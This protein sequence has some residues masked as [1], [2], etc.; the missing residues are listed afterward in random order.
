MNPIA[1]ALHVASR[2]TDANPSDAQKSAGNYAKGKLRIEGMDIAI[3]NPKGS[4]RSGVDPNGKRWECTLP[5]AYGYFLGTVGKDGDHVD[6]YI[7]DDHDSKKVFVIDQIDMKTG[8][9]D[10]HKV[11]LSFP[12][13]D[14]AVENYKKAFSDGNGA[15]RIGH[16]AEMS[17]ERFKE[18]LQN[19]NTKAPIAKGYAS[20][21]AVHGGATS[22]AGQDQSRKVMQAIALA[23][24]TA[25][26]GSQERQSRVDGGRVGRADGGPTRDS[27]ASR[28]ARTKTFRE[29]LESSPRGRFADDPGSIRG[30]EEPSAISRAIGV[31]SMPARL[32]ADQFGRATDSVAEAMGDPSLPNL[33][34]AGVQTGLT[35]GSP[36]LTGTSGALGF[37]LA[38]ARDF[39]PSIISSAGAKETKEKRR[40]AD[41]KPALFEP[42][43]ASAPD[44]IA[45]K[46]K[47]DPTLSLLHS[48]IEAARFDAGKNYPG[49][50]GDASRAQAA[51]R[52][53]QLQA[54]MAEEL[55]KR[56]SAKRDLEKGNYDR[57]V[58]DA[59][60]AREKARSRDK[61]FSD[62]EVGKVYDKL[63]GYAPV[64]AG[65]VPGAAF[66][67]AKGPAKT[68]G[69]ALL[70]AGTGAG[71]GV[72]AIN[73][74]IGYDMA[75]SP[76]VN[77]EKEA[78]RAYAYNLP[79]G[80]PDKAKSEKM[81]AELPESNPVHSAAQDEFS[82]LG[83][84]AK[85][86]AWGALEGFGGQELGGLMPRA[87]GGMFK[88]ST[89]GFGN[90]TPVQIAQ[91]KIDAA[92][93]GAL[94]QQADLATLGSREAA[95]KLAD[96]KRLA[97]PGSSGPGGPASKSGVAEAEIVSNPIVSSSGSPEV[98]RALDVV[99]NRNATP[100]I[101][102]S[103]AAPTATEAT[104]K[105][106]V[107][108][109]FRE[110]GVVLRNENGRKVA[111]H[112]KGKPNGG[113]FTTVPTK[114]SS[115][116]ESTQGQLTNNDVA[117]DKNG[118][119]VKPPKAFDPDDPI[120][121]GY[122]R[123]GI[124]HSAVAL[125][126]KYARGGVVVGPVIGHTGGRAD[127]LP[128]SVPAGAF[129]LPADVVSA[130]GTGN[131]LRGNKALDEMFGVQ[132]SRA[133]GGAVPIKISDGEHVISPETVA[134]IGGGDMNAGH[135]ALEQFILD[136]RRKHI[137]TLK[138]LP[139]PSR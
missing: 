41:L 137:E 64:V 56:D 2:N 48:Q 67:L 99:K 15:E 132:T 13:K 19:G 105:P 114:A 24:E 18:W 49:L 7:G 63:G 106:R 104:S 1:K 20:G 118:I 116:G 42:A 68:W 129:V 26:R 32:Y 134:R 43:T 59:I 22:M 34:N 83:T 65:M 30:Y 70:R 86:S 139:G 72:G 138:S 12:N 113:N 10:E 120:N 119:P 84:M 95:A 107:L 93:A 25:R 136:T 130:L 76:V 133:S 8:K 98:S 50:N 28:L 89:Y 88:P 69:D 112:A 100:A 110:E 96:S 47:D 4:K 54:K 79:D 71:F 45:E 125:A 55:A 27:W 124:T 33:T 46:Y 36:L 57:Q 61:R 122:A 73:V 121:R 108:R 35:I 62:T 11:L 131:T 9:F 29:L 87:I 16:V 103:T 80:H 115:K 53:S 78:M 97:P 90:R 37:G 111:R 102:P 74:P 6:C 75:Y 21:G 85:R 60:F 91:E 77:P 82:D 40:A 39:E 92:K 5:S 126:R 109:H 44:P 101:T 14:A 51:E 17:I 117:V 52:L 123:G 94:G 66:A 128:V 23:L 127:E 135:R 58:E 38:G 81:A 3:E 31:A